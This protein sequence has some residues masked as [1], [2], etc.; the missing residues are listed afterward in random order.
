M[1]IKNYSLVPQVPTTPQKGVVLPVTKPSNNQALPQSTPVNNSF[2]GATGPTGATGATGVAKVAE[3]DL[4]VDRLLR[5]VVKPLEVLV[6]QNLGD[7]Q[8]RQ[9]AEEPD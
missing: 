8:H 2:L 4:C 3:G 5:R 1:P 7:R 6:N 9:H